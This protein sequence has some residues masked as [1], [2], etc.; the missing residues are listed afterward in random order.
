MAEEY[1]LEYAFEVSYDNISENLAEITG[2]TWQQINRF[3]G[4]LQG[5]YVVSDLQ[6]AQLKAFIEALSI[7]R[8][9]A[10]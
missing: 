5:D 10:E 1:A 3:I 7:E 4:I 8:D 6:S 2:C 9:G